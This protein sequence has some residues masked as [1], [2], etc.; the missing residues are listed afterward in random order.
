LTV[1]LQRSK[2]TV[3]QRAYTIQRFLKSI[4]KPLDHITRHDLRQYL[5]QYQDYS[6]ATRSN[7]LKGFKLFFRDFLQQPTL[8]ETFKF[9]TQPFR[10]KRVPSKNNLQLFY[11]TLPSLKN[12]ALFLLYASSGLRRNEVLRLM[13]TDIDFERNMILPNKQATKTKHAWV[14]FFN[15]EA[16][17][18][19]QQYL[20]TRQD[21]NP[22]LFPMARAKETKIWWTTRQQTQLNITPQVVREWFAC[23]MARRKVADRYV[24]AFCGR[25]PR[26]VLA[27]NYTD[28]S[29]ETLQEIYD[30]AGLTVL[31]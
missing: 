10:P 21:K 16:R 2:R 3:K 15:H 30:N 28:Y 5:L 19:L 26:S 11:H 12:R 18:V 13:K 7:L 4:D 17:E 27:R 20:N 1:D 22:K 24:D 8:V 14:S 25:T 9:P 31:E 23:E 29:P 6:V